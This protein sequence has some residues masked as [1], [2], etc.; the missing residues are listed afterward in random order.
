MNNKVN[1][2]KNKPDKKSNV[3]FSEKKISQNKIN[4]IFAPQI[5]KVM[6]R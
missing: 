1:S 3:Y 5:L 6:A 2:Q 4:T